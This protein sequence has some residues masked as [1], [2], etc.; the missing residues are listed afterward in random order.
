VIAYML[1]TGCVAVSAAND[2][3]QDYK[4]LQL[5]GI[6]PRDGFVAQ[7]VGLMGGV[8]FV[9]LSI[10]VAHTAYG[11]GTIRLV[12]PQADLFATLIDGILIDEEIPWWPVAIGLFIGVL[13][14]VMEITGGK[15]NIQVPA[16]AF[17]VGLYLPAEL[18]P[19]ILSGAL[20]RYIGEKLHERDT[21]R[22]ERMYESILAAA[23]MITGAAM[24]DLVMG[25]LVIAG[26]N[27]SS[28]FI[29]PHDGDTITDTWWTITLCALSLIF[30]CWIMYYNSRYGI[31]EA[32][33]SPTAD[34]TLSVSSS[35]AK[36]SRTSL[37]LKEPLQTTELTS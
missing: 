29:G 9:P 22:F 20:F 35:F 14:V 28:L 21:G 25:I 34:G 1:V 27:E 11:L 19:G 36:G 3:A 15:Y 12:A 17:A 5:V 4:T 13:A 26:V 18:G 8:F 2:A 32:S 10:W 31:P 23:G 16:M 7:V 24:L 30:L 37:K 6:P 33:D